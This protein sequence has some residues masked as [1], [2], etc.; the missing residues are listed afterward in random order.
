M[1]RAI[2]LTLVTVFTSCK[3][4]AKLTIASSQQTEPHWTVKENDSAIKSK[5]DYML[6]DH[7]GSEYRPL[8]IKETVV[9]DQMKAIQ[10]YSANLKLVDLKNGNTWNEVF[11]KEFLSNYMDKECWEARPKTIYDLN[12]GVLIDVY[13]FEK[14]DEKKLDILGFFNIS[15]E[16]DQKA[17]VVEFLQE[18]TQFCSGNRYKYGV[19]AR[20]MLHITKVK[21]KAK[22]ATPQQITAS[23][24]FGFAE[25]KFSLKTFGIV[26]PGISNL[27]NAGSLSEDTYQQFLQEISALIKEMY[28]DNDQFII[29]PQPLFLKNK[30]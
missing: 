14:G 5:L 6:K 25:V 15:L 11:T 30:Q 9:L 7:F 24:I 26:G 8:E 1:K 27:N 4:E 22:L 12:D 28:T 16:K 2:F 19:G 29:T 20:L 23:V 10:P 17:V 13:S 3:K 18:G 21:N